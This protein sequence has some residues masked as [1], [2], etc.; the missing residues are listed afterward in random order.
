MAQG[1]EEVLAAYLQAL[2]RGQKAAM[3]VVIKSPPGASPGEGERMMVDGEGNTVG[4]IGG[5]SLTAMVVEDCLKAM[6]RGAPAVV[7]YPLTAQD[8]GMVEPGGALEVF[9]EVPGEQPTLLI[10]G[11]GHI[12]QSLARIGNH[13]GFSIAVV[14]DRPDFANAERFPE[15]DHIMAE[16]FSS[17]LQRFPISESTYIV[18]VTRGHRHDEVSLRQVIDS[19]AAYVGMIGSRR[20]VRAVFQHLEEEGV[21]RH[22]LDRVHS[23]IGLDI[24][25]ETPEEIAVSI[26]AE[27]IKERRG[28]T[29]QP[30]YSRQRVANQ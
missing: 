15:A 19:P 28:G 24:G 8:G 27:I 23:P 2:G 21:S 7:L 4:R 9:I 1:N 6:A 17:A 10:V 14:D 22:L 18:L 20:R 13:L 3:A 30:L 5:E 11:A 16:D 29:G 26:L 12:G 25:A